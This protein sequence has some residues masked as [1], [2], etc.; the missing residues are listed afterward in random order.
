MVQSVSRGI[1]FSAFIYIVKDIISGDTSCFIFCR[2]TFLMAVILRRFLL[3]LLQTF[4]M[5]E[6]DFLTLSWNFF[7]CAG[8]G[9]GVGT[10]EGEWISNFLHW[11][12]E[13]E[14]DGWMVGSRLMF[15]PFIFHNA[16]GW[17]YQPPSS[18]PYR[19]YMWTN[20]KEFILLSWPLLC[21]SFITHS[22][23]ISPY[24]EQ[25]SIP[26]L[27]TLRENVNAATDGE[28]FAERYECGF[29]AL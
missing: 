15:C 9:G 2:F 27:K 19:R 11:I 8:A 21:P 7:L 6:W 18:T 25:C 5:Y 3:S 13:L 16:H 12:T 1:L 10:D 20:P 28:R 29:C 14:K 4:S 24:A 26:A 23:W 22:V 17:P